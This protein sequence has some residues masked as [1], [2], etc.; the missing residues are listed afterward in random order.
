MLYLNEDY[1]D[2]NSTTTQMT[3]GDGVAVLV[4]VA[5]FSGVI[6]GRDDQTS[7]L[8]RTTEHRLD[9]VDQLLQTTKKFAN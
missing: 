3:A 9:D 6:L 5:V 7:P 4:L 8:P 1:I 2:N